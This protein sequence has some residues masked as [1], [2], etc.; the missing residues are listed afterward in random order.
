[1]QRRNL[2]T[3]IT[4]IFMVLRISCKTYLST[5]LSYI[6]KLQFE[7]LNFVKY[8]NGIWFLPRKWTFSNVF[9]GWNDF[10]ALFFYYIAQ[11]KCKDFCAAPCIRVFFVKTIAKWI[12]FDGESFYV[13]SN[14]TKEKKG[15]KR[16]KVNFV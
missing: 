2:Y 9:W 13:K 11:S 12:L 16:Q 14:L 4:S 6:H 15:Q 10:I 7:V 1:M 8:W 5:N 3:D